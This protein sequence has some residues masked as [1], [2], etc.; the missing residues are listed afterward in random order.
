MWL[1]LLFVW[2]LCPEN[3][4]LR[5]IGFD[6]SKRAI[7]FLNNKWRRVLANRGRTV[8]LKDL[9]A[10]SEETTGPP[11]EQSAAAP[12]P[13]SPLQPSQPTSSDDEEMAAAQG[14]QDRNIESIPMEVGELVH[15]FVHDITKG[16][17]PEDVCPSGSADF[18]LL[19]FVLSALAPA[20]FRDVAQRISRV[21]RPGG[22]LML[23]D[24]GRYD[25]AQLRFAAQRKCKIEENF[26]VR[27]DG[28]RTY[29]FTVEELR[30]IFC[31]CG[32]VELEN[33]YHMREI[34]NRKTEQRM[35][36]IWIQ[37]KFE[38][39]SHAPAAAEET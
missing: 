4:H 29:Y 2:C 16:D 9:N 32:L 12:E 17:P 22:V 24:Y 31:G 26:Y 27:W 10:D 21:L 28:T 3:P 23:R 8:N 20:H 7:D 11:G 30:E 5:A 6:I 34:V 33:R 14:Q 35:R 38:K 36:R 25:M 18:A 15:G 1:R 19:L 39:P 37:A 13:P